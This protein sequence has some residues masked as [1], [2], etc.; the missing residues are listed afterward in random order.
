MK[1][2]SVFISLAHISIVTLLMFSGTS[3]SQTVDPTK[4]DNTFRVNVVNPG[5]EYEF[6]L[7]NTLAISLGTGVGY[8]GNFEEITLAKESGFQYDIA[9]FIDSQLKYI[10]NRPRRNYKGKNLAFNS[11]N[12]LSLRFLTRLNSLDAN[13]VRTTETD[14]SIG[15]TYGLQ[16]SFGKF[17]FLLD[18]GPVYYFD[19]SGNTGWYPFIPQLNIGWN[20]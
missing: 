16:R 14:Y 18:I 7:S 9:P 1:E 10:Y 20:L 8:S 13:F 17:H 19:G 3:H 12:Y 11:G 5:V 15:L 4:L 2:L 6:G